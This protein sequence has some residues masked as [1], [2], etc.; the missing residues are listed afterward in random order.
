MDHAYLEM[1][2]SC[3]SKVVSHYISQPGAEPPSLSLCDDCVQTHTPAFARDFTED[4]SAEGCR[5]CGGK[6]AAS[7]SLAHVI[8][9]AGAEEKFLC[10]SCALEYHRIGLR[11]FES[12]LDPDLKADERLREIMAQIDTDMRR[13]VIQ[14]DN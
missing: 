4:L 5:F 10:R 11:Y 1:C 3:E 12:P 13:W 8:D 2:H 9:G 14:R 7:D 6:A